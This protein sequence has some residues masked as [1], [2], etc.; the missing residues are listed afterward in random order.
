MAKQ[1]TTTDLGFLGIDYQIQ[2][3]RY[4]IEDPPFF[5][6]IESLVDQNMFTDDTLRQIVGFM[7]DRYS[8]TE[9]VTTYSDLSLIIRS[10]VKDTINVERCLS[11]LEKIKIMDDFRIDL[12]EENAEKFFKQQNIIKA[13]NKAQDIIREGKCGRYNEI[14]DIFKEALALNNKKDFGYRIFDNMEDALKEDYRHTIPTGASDL[15]KV[16]LGGLGK[17]ELGVIIAPSNVG[18]AQPLTSKVLTPTGYKC[19][20]DIKIG[21]YVIG[22][23]GKAHNVIGVYPQGIRPVYKVEFS[24]GTSCECDI[25]HLW[26]VKTY[27]KHSKRKF[28]TVSLREILECGVTKQFNGKTKYVFTIPTVK[29]VEFESKILPI[30]P[31]V[32]GKYL[33]GKT[34][35]KCE[36]LLGDFWTGQ[37][38]IPEI[39]LYSDIA[40][41]TSLL[42]GLIENGGSINKK[43]KC[44]FHSS[45]KKIV[46]QMQFLVRSL[47]G[48][49]NIHHV[50]TYYRN[51]DERT[52]HLD[53][54]VVEV[55]LTGIELTSYG[56]HPILYVKNDAYNNYKKQ[57]YITNV[58]YLR[59][60][61]TQCILV[62]S[63]EHLYVTD[64]FIVTH[65]TSATTGFAAAAA[66][67]ACDENNGRGYKVLHI[68]FEDVEVNIKR[69][70]YAFLTGVDACDLSKPTV[71]PQ[72][73][74]TLNQHK[75]KN[76]LQNNIIGWRPPTG[77]VSPTDIK[78]K[79]RQLISNGFKPDVLI[80]DY[81][82]CLKLE[83]GSSIEDNAFTR[84]GITMRKLETIAHEFNIAIWCPVQGTKDSF[85][86]QIVGMAQAGG[87]VKK[88][89]IGHVVISFARTEQMKLENKLN[90]FVNKFRGGRI[91]KNAFYNVTFNNGTTRFDFSTE[92]DVDDAI[93]GTQSYNTNMARQV[94]NS[95]KTV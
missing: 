78:A 43:G 15:D 38:E 40:D 88:V 74:E 14:E 92:T 67:H 66:V 87:S 89:Q 5:M 46:E 79:I 62:N 33:G 82:E 29:P 76:M 30:H 95:Y 11:M 17:G 37:R 51:K 41:R 24:N 71:R 28:R 55:F 12:V 36:E 16:L 81:F 23:D 93:D 34:N 42:Q 4:F 3:V 35:S 65:N 7:K 26:N 60:D 64:D 68:H 57:V 21:D 58:T 52:I 18:K 53:K 39:Y 45:S 54:Y 47:G 32:V 83:K 8:L 91:D 73:I 13:I 20:G 63:E 27:S 1:Q 2:L 19:M 10:K 25:D 22:G 80:V 84:E 70:Y 50:D 48:V 6:N 61:K 94:K 72:I 69:K 31:Y 44:L 86:Q 90:I 77:E 85:N 49:A 9:S 56:E 59:E 75:W